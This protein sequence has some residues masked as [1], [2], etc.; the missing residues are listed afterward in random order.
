MDKRNVYRKSNTT[1]PGMIV[2]PDT[3]YVYYKDGRHCKICWRCFRKD[4]IDIPEE[5]VR[6]GFFRVSKWEKGKGG[7]TPWVDHFERLGIPTHTDVRAL[8]GNKT[9]ALYRYG[10]EVVDEEESGDN[11]D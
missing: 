10:L 4:T 11:G 1:Y 7:L 2:C 9:Y 5:I 3:G 6:E 8:N